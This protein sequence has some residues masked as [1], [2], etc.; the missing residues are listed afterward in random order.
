LREGFEVLVMK[1]CLVD[2]Q[3]EMELRGMFSGGTAKS[4]AQFMTS[5]DIFASID[6]KSTQPAPV[7][8][9]AMPLI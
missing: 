5:A 2:N 4:R 8:A 3:D 1:D 7:S 6:A 9:L